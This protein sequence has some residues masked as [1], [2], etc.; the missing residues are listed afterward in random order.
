MKFSTCLNLII[1]GISIAL[2]PSRKQNV[3]NSGVESAF[4][5]GKQGNHCLSHDLLFF[6]FSAI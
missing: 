6:M 2:T 5:S 4:R 1:I 3:D